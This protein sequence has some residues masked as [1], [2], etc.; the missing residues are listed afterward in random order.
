MTT[1]YYVGFA[2]MMMRRYEDAIRSFV[3][4]LLYVQRAKQVI[5][6]KSYQFEEVRFLCFLALSSNL[7]FHNRYLLGTVLICLLVSLFFSQWQQTS[8]QTQN[9]VIEKSKVSWE[10]YCMKLKTEMTVL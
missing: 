8:S 6:T 3:N 2:Y 9:K 1:Y 10:K 5:Q 7:E 4:V